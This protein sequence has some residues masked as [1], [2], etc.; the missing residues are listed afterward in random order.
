MAPTADADEAP[1]WSMHAVEMPAWIWVGDEYCTA[2]LLSRM[3]RV[4]FVPAGRLTV[5]L[6]EVDSC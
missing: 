4:R 2:P 6:Y 5:Q 1:A 3:E